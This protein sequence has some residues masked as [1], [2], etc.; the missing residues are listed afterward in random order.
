MVKKVVAEAAH[1]NAQ[2]KPVQYVSDTGVECKV[3]GKGTMHVR[4]QK[5]NARSSI[6]QQLECPV[7]GDAWPREVTL[8]GKTVVTDP[9]RRD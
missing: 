7:C 9:F 6:V 4:Q 3:C 2:S 8:D 1:L 5:E